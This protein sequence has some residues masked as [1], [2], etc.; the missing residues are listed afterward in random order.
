MLGSATRPTR[1]ATG[2]CPVASRVVG[3]G[4]CPVASPGRRLE[5]LVFPSE[6]LEL[7]AELGA[8][9]GGGDGGADSGAGA[10][11][12]SS[13]VELSVTV[14]VDSV[15]ISASTLPPRIWASNASR[16]WIGGVSIGGTVGVNCC[17]QD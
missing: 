11:E 5:P 4:H 16:T 6:L 9:G 2:H 14:G 7:S 10:G 8:P 13:P 17:T 1:L 3:T 12:P 15:E